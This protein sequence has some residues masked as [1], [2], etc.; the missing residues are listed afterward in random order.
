S[1]R[2]TYCV[3]EPGMDAAIRMRQTLR[4]DL[5]AAF[6][7]G[8][9]AVHF[10]P[11]L[12]VTTNTIC[13]YEALLRWNHP[14]KG[15]IS[16]VDFIPVAEESGFIVEL[17]KWVLTEACRTALQWPNGERVAVNV[18]GIQSRDHDFAA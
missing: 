12:N 16:P 2:S 9:F 11:Q 17:G 10:Q 1:G 14:V 13:G 6:E 3:F 4:S 18:S 7:A 5:A 8:E 15:S